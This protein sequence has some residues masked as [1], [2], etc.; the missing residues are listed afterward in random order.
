MSAE[1]LDVA[2]DAH[3]DW[4]LVGT[5][6]EPFTLKILEAAAHRLDVT[7]E[8]S[9][10]YVDDKEIHELNRTY[11][12]VDRP[13]DVLSFAMTEG[14]DD[15]PN[16]DAPTMLGDIVISVDKAREQAAEYNHS[17]ERE[18]AFLLVHGF[19]H[20]N[21]YDHQDDAGEREMFGLQ[22]EILGTLGITR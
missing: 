17:L 14:E 4:P 5:D 8:V 15:F 13:T 11:R 2:I 3:V 19:L 21:G 7:G 1:R 18:M 16:F 22:D 10:L 9:V 20:L 12:D 6:M